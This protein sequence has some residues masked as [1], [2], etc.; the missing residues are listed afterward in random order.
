MTIDTAHAIATAAKIS[1]GAAL[2][3]KFCIHQ[4]C[5]VEEMAAHKDWSAWRSENRIVADAAR[6]VGLT[7]FN[8]LV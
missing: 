5:S 4:H 3:A 7:L 2:Y 8:S 1:E 6:A